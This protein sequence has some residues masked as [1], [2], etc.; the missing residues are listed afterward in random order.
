MYDM[1]ASIRQRNCQAKKQEG[2]L[3]SF[4]RQKTDEELSLLV[5]KNK[6]K[7]AMEL[8][9][10]TWGE[11]QFPV[12]LCCSLLGLWGARKIWSFS[13]QRV[14][15]CYI[16]RTWDIAL[17]RVLCSSSSKWSLHN[18]TVSSGWLVAFLNNESNLIFSLINES[19]SFLN[20]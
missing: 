6:S 14:S 18:H 16:G 12:P 7:I 3:L 2:P 19:W 4:L 1:R 10:E 5:F 11:K 9:W 15:E 8:L 17:H 20:R 13:M